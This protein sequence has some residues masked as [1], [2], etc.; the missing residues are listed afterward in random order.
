MDRI[1]D[2]RIYKHHSLT[3]DRGEPVTINFE[4]KRIKAFSLEPV[5]VA[6]FAAGVPVTMRSFKY[7]RPRGLFCV[8]GKCASCLMRID[9]V[10]NRRACTVRC[11]DGMMVQRQ[12]AFP[13][14]SDDL[15]FVNDFLFPKKLDYHHLLTRP[16]WLNRAL[17][18]A[19]RA[20]SGLGDLPDAPPEQKPVIRDIPCDVL[21]V[22]A[23]PAGIAS[24]LAAAS[25]RAKVIMV[26]DHH[27]P[28]GHLLAYPEMIDDQYSGLAYC[29]ERAAL[30]IEKGIRFFNEN[31]VIGFYEEGCFVTLKEGQL[32]RLHP[33]R[34]I[35]ATGGYDQNFMFSQSDLPNIF[36]ARGLA[37]LTVRWGICPG[38]RIFLLGSND[39]VLSLA[40]RLPEIGVR[41]VGI[42]EPGDRVL[43]NPQWAEAIQSRGVPIFLNYLPSRA[44]GRFHL[45]GI[46]L[47]P[48]GGGEKV[49]TRCDLI[50]VGAPLSPAFELAAQA[51]VDV[52][53][54]PDRGGYV[55]EHD[56]LGRTNVPEIFVA[57][58]ITGEMSVAKARHAGRLA[59]MTAAL[60][61]V[62]SAAVTA[63]RDR[64]VESE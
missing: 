42:A 58:E 23:G 9:G 3:F 5:A 48:G 55:P 56:A 63:R 64:L 7:H 18:G 4:G 15:L 34:T 28:G 35:L 16:A 27:R 57:G 60:D 19:V 37:K 12:G 52:R 1:R 17:S 10:P 13:N 62:P 43:G 36:S 14:A 59:G 6:L 8:N 29:F 31:E 24:S 45:K 41:V 53:F 50:A 2:L 33:K 26:D 51:G 54:D 40:L 38:V 21:V 25:A 30:L 61:V 22:G 47:T 20:L 49:R 44:I 39:Q 46:E 32:I 11:H